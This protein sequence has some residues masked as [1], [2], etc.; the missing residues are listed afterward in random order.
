M[1]PVNIDTD[2]WKNKEFN[3]L[4]EINKQNIW[5]PGCSNCQVLEFSNNTSFRIGMNEGLQ[6]F[7]QTDIKGPSR[8]DLI[9]DISC[10][11]ACRS[12]GPESSTYWR[13]HLKEN[14]LRNDTA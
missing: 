12:C 8:I 2:F 5:D 9:F 10:N 14:K 13:Q 7:G 6:I 3:Q 1:F 11:L 4:R